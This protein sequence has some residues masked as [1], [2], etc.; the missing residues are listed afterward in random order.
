M[1]HHADF[2][3]SGR[4]LI[5]CEE[6]NRILENH[7]LAISAGKII[8]ILP[9][10]EARKKYE[11]SMQSFDTHAILPGFINAHT[12]LAMNAFRGLADD[13]ALL[14]WL[15]DYIWPAETKWVSE[16][17]VYDASKLAI[18]ELIRSGS[19]CYNDM[20][21]FPEATAK[22]TEEA[23]IRGHIGMTIIDV[24]TVFAK[25]TEEYF[26]RATEFYAA[27]CDHPLVTPTFAPHS[28]YTV[29]LE[30]LAK[31]HELA[32]AQNCRINI[33]LQ[34]A[35]SEVARSYELYQK[36]TTGA[37]SRHWHDFRKINCSSY[38]A[39]QR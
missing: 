29:S 37:F 3:V 36:K 6:T 20:Y 13:L 39:N 33:H 4:Y 14:D 10:S 35:A 12:H 23:G 38:D 32:V 26:A 18:A 21:F 24:P 31:V 8:D 19:T 7:T 11:A 1:K 28:T 15:N 2:L 34:E 9:T 5:T 30:N 25:N 17:F 27:F 16:E 22:A